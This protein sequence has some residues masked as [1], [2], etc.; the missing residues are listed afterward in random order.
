[1]EVKGSGVIWP[2]RVGHAAM[3]YA[4]GL[5]TEWIANEVARRLKLWM[6]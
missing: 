6:R 2:W 1:M 5:P 3:S 4:A